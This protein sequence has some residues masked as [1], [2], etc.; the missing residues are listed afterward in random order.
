MRITWGYVLCHHYIFSDLGMQNMKNKTVLEPSSF[1]LCA[2]SVSN[3]TFCTCICPFL[4]KV[5]FNMIYRQY[6]QWS[7]SHH[8][9]QNLLVLCQRKQS[10]LPPCVLNAL[11]FGEHPHSPHLDLTSA[12]NRQLKNTPGFKK[13]PCIVIHCSFVTADRVGMAQTFHAHLACLKQNCSC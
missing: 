6:M 8:F 12:K 2:P 1:V 10:K 4:T 11:Y 13:H 7:C 3:F 9:C 5:L